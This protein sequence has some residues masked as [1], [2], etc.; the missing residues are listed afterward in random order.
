MKTSLGPFLITVSFSS[1]MLF[2][3]VSNQWL[4]FSY[5]SVSRRR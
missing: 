2:F 4:R 3:S 1:G 5:N